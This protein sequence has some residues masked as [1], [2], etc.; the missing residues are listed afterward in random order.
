MDKKFNELLRKIYEIL[1]PLGY[2]KEASN[3]RLFSADGLCTII[4]LQKNKW[5]TNE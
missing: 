3:Y 5:N 4:N 1:K 2:R